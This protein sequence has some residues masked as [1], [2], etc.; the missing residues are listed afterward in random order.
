MNFLA[1]LALAGPDTDLQAGNL[2]ADW[3]K[4]RRLAELPP[5]V[6]AGVVMHRALD[7]YTDHHPAVRRSTAR[8]RGRWGLYSAILVDVLYDHLLARGFAGTTGSELRP[9]LDARYV[10]LRRTAP[11]LPTREACRLERLICDDR[12]YSYTTTAGVRQ[13]L[14]R[15]S[16]QLRRRPCLWNAV[17]DFTNAEEGFQGDF[18]EFWRDV[19]PEASRLA[20]QSRRLPNSHDRKAGGD[21]DSSRPR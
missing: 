14:R 4:G 13:A 1:H 10:S 16:L 3:I 21:G 18:G 19:V 9:W 2:I 15:V 7:V 12:L 8:L 20:G 17:E 6:Q 11:R 5:A